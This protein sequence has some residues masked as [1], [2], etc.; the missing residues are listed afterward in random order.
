[1][2]TALANRQRTCLE[3]ADKGNI[4]VAV[5]NVRKAKSLVGRWL[6]RSPVASENDAVNKLPGETLIER[7]TVVLVDVAVGR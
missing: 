6:E 1:M 4:K 3:K 2:A 7:D 5:I